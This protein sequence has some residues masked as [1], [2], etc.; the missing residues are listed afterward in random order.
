MWSAGYGPRVQLQQGEQ[1]SKGW[2]QCFVGQSLCTQARSQCSVL[3][4]LQSS[5][6]LTSGASSLLQYL[7]LFDHASYMV[8][9]W[10]ESTR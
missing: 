8:A 5:I 6:L 4:K 7:V 9:D 2:A 10:K 3:Q 1:A